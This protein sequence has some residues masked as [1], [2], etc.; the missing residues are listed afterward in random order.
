MS[1]HGHRLYMHRHVTTPLTHCCVG[2]FPCVQRAHIQSFIDKFRCSASRAALVQSR[3]KALA[4][5]DA[6]IDVVEE[7]QTTFSFPEPDR[8]DGHILSASNVKFGYHYN[9]ILLDKV[10]L[11]VDMDSRIGVIGANGTGKTTLIHLLVGKLQAISGTITRNGSARVAV[12]A[13]HHVDGLD[14]RSSSVDM[15]CS[16]FP[17]INPQVFRRHLGCF[18]I[19]GDLATNPI[20]T[21]SGGQKSRVAFAVVTWKKPYVNDSAATQHHHHASFTA[22][23]NHTHLTDACITTQ[24]VAVSRS[25]TQEP[26][27]ASDSSAA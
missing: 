24:C 12:F 8:L 23:N 22:H 2:S 5:M 19:T 4:K 27:R 21:L 26:W 10:T 25:R 15:M 18:G 6:L 3:I 16:I 11:S 13:Q 1:W 20:K 7:H 14:L 9:K 17:G